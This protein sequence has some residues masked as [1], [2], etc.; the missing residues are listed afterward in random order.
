MDSPIK[1]I[2][3]FDSLQ[4]A[5]EYY[6]DYYRKNGYPN[7]SFDN[8]DKHR[9]IEKLIGF[10][11]STII[12]NGML[13]QTMHSCG[14]LWCYFPHW[15]NTR[16]LSSKSVYENWNDDDKLRKLIKKNIN[17]CIKHEGGKWSTN[18][19]RQN[20][21]VYCSSSSVS[22]FRPT[23]AKY[24]YNT[25][26]NKGSVY[27]PCG[28][29]GGRLFGFLASDCKNYTCCEPSTKSFEGLKHISDDFSYIGKNVTILNKCAEDYIPENNSVDMCFTSP[30]YFNTEMYSDEDT[31][32]YKRYQSYEEWLNGFLS[33][34]IE[35][36]YYCLKNDGYFLL[37]IANV[38]TAPTLEKDAVTIALGNGF[39]LHDTLHL[40]L[41]SISGKGVKTE[42]IFIFKKD[43]S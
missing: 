42:P 34:M 19:I 2:Y 39:V 5:Q 15:I 26:G 10:D 7:Y 35:N 9:E 8:Y 13:K 20:A 17:Y 11:D 16:T 12:N 38:K 40:I 32:S 24:L 22:N 21:K 33:K 14:F 27:D 23:A 18:R 28:G 30:P 25:Y 1:N 41:S 6:F 37:N 29:W 36:C 4:D 43:N 3:Y 31:Q